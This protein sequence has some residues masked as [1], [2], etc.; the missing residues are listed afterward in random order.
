[1]KSPACSFVSANDPMGS[2]ELP[3]AP[4]ELLLPWEGQTQKGWQARLEEW[5][6]R[7]PTPR[8]QHCEPSCH[9]PHPY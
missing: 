3:R 1:M 5:H 8:W 9:L 2:P 6:M 4:R 7:H